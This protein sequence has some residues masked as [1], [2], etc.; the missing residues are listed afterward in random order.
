MSSTPVIV[1]G[2]SFDLLE[3]G[4]N[5]QMWK[6][7]CNHKRLARVHHKRIILYYMDNKSQKRDR[8]ITDIEIDAF[9]LLDGKMSDVVMERMHR[10]ICSKLV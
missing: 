2:T 4:G 9:D 3:K 1:R 5:F 7:E 10:Q 8:N 6:S